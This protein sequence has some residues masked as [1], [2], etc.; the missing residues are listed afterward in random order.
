MSPAKPRVMMTE[1]QVLAL[2]PVVRSTIWKWVRR[3]RF[4]K[5]VKIATRQKAWYAD[6]VAA[7]QR[8]REEAGKRAPSP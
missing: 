5:P 7:W 3:G 4:P 1:K 6:E 2:I 8:E